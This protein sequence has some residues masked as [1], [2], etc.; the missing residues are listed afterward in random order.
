MQTFELQAQ[1]RDSV[2]KEH[3]KR[4]R[5]EGK[6]PAVL[7]TGGNPAVSL[8]LP[9]KELQRLLNAHADENL[10]INLQIQGVGNKTAIIREVQT[11][12]ISDVIL[13]VD[14]K[15]VSM[16][17]TIE[18][19]V[20]VHHTGEAAGVKMGGVLDHVRREIDVE[21]LPGNI[22]AS[23]DVDV[24]NLAIGKSIHVSDLILPKGVVCLDAP[25]MVLMTVLL[26]KGEEVVVEGEA[27]AGEPEV[28]KK[29]KEEEA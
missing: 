21:C 9:R 15:E 19:K 2:G 4:I 23:I 10:L 5:R 28:I 11:D 7:Y 12:P 17:E 26:P 14:F 6:V 16:T 3:A 18:V 29:G 22:P 13:H 25:D 27:G 24:T 1:K 8:E 20:A